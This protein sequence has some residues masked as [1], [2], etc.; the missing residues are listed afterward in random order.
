MFLFLFYNDV[1]WNNVNAEHAIKLLGKHRDKHYIHFTTNN[2]E[3]YLK[4]MNIYQ[5]CKY[6]EISFL[7]FLLSKE[8]DLDNYCKQIISGKRKKYNSIYKNAS[9]YYN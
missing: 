5:T 1:S 9:H 4:I 8:K 3:S 2:I 6:K 7:K